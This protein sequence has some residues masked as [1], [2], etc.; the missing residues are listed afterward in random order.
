ME[1]FKWDFAPADAPWQNGVSE[2]L[3]KSMKLGITAAISD[4]IMTFSDLQ[5]FASR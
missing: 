4:H 5:P 1:E 2:A 3:V